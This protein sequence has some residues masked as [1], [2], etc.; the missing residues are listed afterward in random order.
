[1]SKTATDRPGADG[2]ALLK[3]KARS[4][5]REGEA[6]PE[7][8]LVQNTR[9]GRTLALQYRL[10]IISNPVPRT[11]PIQKSPGTPLPW[12]PASATSQS[13]PPQSARDAGCLCS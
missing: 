11:P 9:L 4:A 5:N 6:P 1:M 3:E 12:S 8:S 10:H 2:A 13:S 7:P